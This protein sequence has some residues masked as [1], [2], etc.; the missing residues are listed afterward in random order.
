MD[1][2]MLKYLYFLNEHVEK[3]WV[4]LSISLVNL[5]FLY[6]CTFELPTFLIFK[7]Q[8]WLLFQKIKIPCVTSF[9]LLN[10]ASTCLK[11][12]VASYSMIWTSKNS[13]PA[14]EG[15]N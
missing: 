10:L 3:K 9:F 4:S 12:I 11:E 6:F 13:K 1:I 8:Y 14:V 5:F 15:G 2:D 7:L